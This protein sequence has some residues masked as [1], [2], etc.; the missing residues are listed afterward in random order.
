MLV[1]LLI[2]PLIH[3]ALN[4][5]LHLFK[6]P[7]PDL[8]AVFVLLSGQFDDAT[9]FTNTIEALVG[10]PWHVTAYF[11]A[12]SLLGLVL[13]WAAQRFVRS[14]RLDRT[15]SAFRFASDWHYLFKGK[16]AATCRRQ[17]S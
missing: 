7:A 3:L 4:A 16:S 13:G 12:A 9:Q 14:S 2:A 1:A 10:W 5:F 11:L 6:A 17:T 8:R 15:F